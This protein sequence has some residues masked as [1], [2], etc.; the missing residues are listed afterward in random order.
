MF[1]STLDVKPNEH[2]EYEVAKGVSASIFR[3]IMVR[4]SVCTATLKLYPYQLFS[5]Y[6]KE[7]YKLGI[8]TCPAS[9]SIQ[10]MKEA[11]DYLMIPFDDKTIKTNNL[12]GSLFPHSSLPS[13]L[14]LPVFALHVLNFELYIQVIFLMNYP[15]MVPSISLKSM[16]AKTYFQS[17]CIV[18]G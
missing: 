4:E 7:F 16:L 14:P 13:L 12:G 11:C 5:L 6:F 17:W 3:A 10:E 1:S 15:M 18:L 9:E 2:G 8:V